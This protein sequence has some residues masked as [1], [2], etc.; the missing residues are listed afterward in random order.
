MKF[1][2]AALL[3]MM[4][5]SQVP[6][7]SGQAGVERVWLTVKPDEPVRERNLRQLQNLGQPVDFGTCLDLPAGRST[8][9]GPGNDGWTLAMG[10]NDDGSSSAVPLGFQF[11]LFGTNYGSVYINNNGNLSFETSYSSFT[12]SGFPVSGRKMVAP[13]W[14]DV[15]TRS[16]LG[17]VWQKQVGN[18]L[19][20]AWDHVGYYSVQGDKRNTFQVMISDGNDPAM[21]LGNNVCFCYGQMQ[22]TT[23]RASGGVNGFG[24][25]PATVGVNKGV[26]GLYS[27]FFGRPGT[28]AQVSQLSGESRCFPVS[29]NSN[30]PPI[31]HGVPPGGQVEIDCD[32]SIEDLVITF[33][34]PENNQQVTLSATGVTNGVTVD[35]VQGQTATAT[36]NWTPDFADAGIPVTVILHATDSEGGESDLTVTLLAYGPVCMEG[37]QGET[38]A[39]P[40]GAFGDPHFKTWTGEYYDFHGICD[41][42]L[43]DAPEFDN[44]S[45]LSVHLRTKERYSY[46]YIESA[47]VKIGDDI[48]EVSSWGEYSLNGVSRCD[49]PQTMGNNQ[50]P[51]T[52]KKKSD[53]SHSY[54]IAV[55]DEEE[56]VVTSFKDMVA[57][58]VQNASRANFGTSVG[59]MGS[60][61]DGSF[62]GRDG[63]TVVGDHDAFGQEWQVLA[64]EP[65]LF[66][67]PSAH[68]GKTCVAPAVAKEGRRRLGEADVARKA[69]EEACAEHKEGVVF[70]M[71][72][73]DVLAMDDL[74]VANASGAY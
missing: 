25:T 34:A 68:L 33:A 48:L 22:W 59:M 61:E 30:I 62:I 36:I 43:V 12:S 1:S 56:I 28:A 55:S 11:D 24:G 60:F 64:S 51:L 7:T 49:L 16:G 63:T 6:A 19:A 31:A 58:S 70:D 20:V 40:P 57:V 37:R 2:S 3:S 50:L 5:L 39:S 15:D 53:K 27:S 8:G 42:V 73:F 18:T 38:T 13:F 41:L 32:E 65:Q 45:G 14:A 21:G 10:G 72:V 69:A 54:H 23:G 71:C 44:G 9:G 46:S 74:E 66:Q 17:H 4:A 47:A 67:T 52:Y 35:L 29:V 26:D